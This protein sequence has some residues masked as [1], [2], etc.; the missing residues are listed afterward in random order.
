[1]DKVE[2]RGKQRHERI[3]PNFKSFGFSEDNPHSSMKKQ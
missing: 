1:M 2:E 3:N